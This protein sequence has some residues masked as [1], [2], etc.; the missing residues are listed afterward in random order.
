V[1]ASFLR[2]AGFAAIALWVIAPLIVR[3]G[4]PL[5]V[6]DWVWSPWAAHTLWTAH[7]SYSS[8]SLAGLG[9]PNSAVT[10]NPLAWLKIVSCAFFDGRVAQ[11]VYLG[12]SLVV[13]FAG[14]HRLARTNLGL[15]ERFAWLAIFAFAGSPFVFAKIASGQSSYWPSMAAF[16]WGVSFA[17]EALRSRDIA[18]ALAAAV[19]FALA[20]LQAQFL[21]FSI[22]ATVLLALARPRATR[23]WPFAA[24][25][26][27]CTPVLIFPEVWFLLER[28]PEHGAAISHVYPAWRRAQSSA[29]PYAPAMLGYAARYVERALGARSPGSV[30]VIG[31]AL[32]MIGFGLAAVRLRANPMQRAL[33][34]FAI[35]GSL[36]ISGVDGPAAPLWN[37]AFD[38]SS[39]ASYLR[40]F[41]HAAIFVAL[42]IALSFA[43][44]IE[45]YARRTRWAIPLAILLVAV[46]GAAT[47]SFGLARAL[48]TTLPRDDRDAVAR[49]AAGG[50]G[51]RVA[52]LPARV[53]LESPGDDIGGN[54][55]TDWA[56]ARYRSIFEYYLEPAAAVAVDAMH[57]GDPRGVALLERLGC[58]A[59]DVRAWVRTRAYGDR[60][61]A[62]GDALVRARLASSPG[63]ESRVFALAGYAPLSLARA[64]APLPGDLRAMRRD[65]GLAYLDIPGDDPADTL[66]TA[67]YAPDPQRGW[68]TRR[69]TRDAGAGGPGGPSYGIV[70]DLRGARIT[71]GA[72]AGSRALVWSQFSGGLLLD[73][74][75]MTAPVPTWISGNGAIDALDRNGAVAIYE[76][77]ERGFAI[78]TALKQQL[79]TARLLD[80]RMLAPWH[81]TLRANLA[82]A[83]LVVLRERFDPDWRLAGDGVTVVRHLRADGYA[84]AWLVRG[85]GVRTI[86]ITY[87]GQAPTWTLLALSAVAFAA[88]LLAAYVCERGFR[89][90][91][92]KR[93]PRI[94]PA[95][96]SRL[97]RN[98]P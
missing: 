74:R 77:G 24:L 71:I 47:W 70:S 27:A 87:A 39:T 41:Y 68:V 42:A 44:G 62:T 86:D 50:A 20:T 75:P 95:R 7:F 17:E 52:F 53:P 10:L 49:V 14:V 3:P 12:G 32:A 22:L 2:S 63:D 31:A 45:T 73:G 25:V 48:P 28:G 16:V 15:G 36:W 85:S 94:D 92:T 72:A 5:F 93:R 19:C 91:Q 6:H 11:L 66:A 54:D 57:A 29:L 1:R 30:A 13:A 97:D 4:M 34:F 76:T 51:D 83:A 26:I 55:G 69:D 79:A 96:A 90:S 89:A 60:P 37:L 84:N 38:R 40:E 64:G 59:V 80:A 56:D 23:S 18:R 33:L 43:A 98:A 78:D 61:D 65:P 67:A 81:A 35:L 88:L 21:V 9:S 82:G 46:F 8:W 58:D